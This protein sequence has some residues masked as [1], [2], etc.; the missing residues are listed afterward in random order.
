MFKV[1]FWNPLKITD[2]NR[3]T[4]TNY[5]YSLVKDGR[6]MRISTIMSQRRSQS[7]L[8]GFRNYAGTEFTKTKHW[9]G[10]DSLE[11]KIP[12]GTNLVTITDNIAELKGSDHSEKITF[13]F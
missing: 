7:T 11:T 5:A 4:R 9:I 12:E 8:S 6:N 2:L 13:D 3:T 1:T 10:L